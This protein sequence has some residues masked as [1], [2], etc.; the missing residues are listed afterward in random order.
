MKNIVFIGSGAIATALGNMFASTGT[1]NVTLLS[2]ETEVIESIKKHHVNQKYFPIYRLSRK[3][4][5]TSNTRILRTADFIFIAI[6]SVAVVSYFKEHVKDVN[7]NALI[8]NLAKGFGENMQLIPDNLSTLIPNDLVVM[9][10]P[11]FAREILDGQPTAFTIASRREHV[12]LDFEALLKNTNIHIDFT[13]DVTGVEYCSILK[14]IYAIIIGIVDASFD[15]S[16]LRSMIISKSINEIRHLMM[17]FGGKEHTMFNY[18]GFGD[19]SLTA[20]NDLSRNRT[21]GLLIG[22]GLFIEDIAR[23]VVLEGRIAVDVFHEKIVKSE[24][25]LKPHPLLSELYKIFNEP[26]YDIKGFVKTIVNA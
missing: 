19:F 21:L 25:D 7:P 11:S 3:L 26:K 20:L 18:C 1:D 8:V 16:N 9:K 17:A 13:N 22:K 23:H 12:Y 4:K 10:G 2:I 6:P 15:S 5:A 24:I 14:N